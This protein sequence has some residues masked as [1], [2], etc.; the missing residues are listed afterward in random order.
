MMLKLQDIVN[1]WDD[2]NQLPVEIRMIEEK[3]QEYQSQIPSE[4]EAELTAFRSECC[5]AYFKFGFR[6][7]VTLLVAG[8]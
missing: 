4:I 3:Y 7:A 6:Q 1:T 8:E 2:L 5:D